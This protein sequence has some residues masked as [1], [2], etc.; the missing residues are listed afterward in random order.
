MIENGEN[1]RRVTFDLPSQHVGELMGILGDFAAHVNLSV[2]FVDSDATVPGIASEADR[3][4]F[5]PELV[6]SFSVEDERFDVITWKNLKH[7]ENRLRWPKG[8]AERTA[9]IFQR[10]SKG[11]FC[12]VDLG[13]RDHLYLA[14][15]QAIPAGYRRKGSVGCCNT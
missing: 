8:A 15:F 5:N 12:P 1:L 4:A 3:P 2:T 13:L 10:Y 14:E 6:R 9:N 7:L 11:K